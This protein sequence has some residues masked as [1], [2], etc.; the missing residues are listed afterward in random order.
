M[1]AIPD[2]QIELMRRLL[3]E[4]IEL[5]VEPTMTYEKGD[6]VEVTAGSLLGLR[7]TLVNIQGKDKMLVE[8][9]N[10]GYTLQISIDKGLL[11]KIIS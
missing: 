9:V 8:L 5:T 3:G 6:W 2:E 10:S 4:G 1:L 11:S 7:G